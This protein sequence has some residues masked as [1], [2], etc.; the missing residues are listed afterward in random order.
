MRPGLGS[1]PT[2]TPVAL[3]KAATTVSA[4]NRKPIGENMTTKKVVLSAKKG[5]APGFPGFFGW[6]AATHPELY[7]RAQAALPDYATQYG[8]SGN[9]ANINVMAGLGAL[10]ADDVLQD[11]SAPDF[12][13]QAF[14]FGIT[15]STPLPTS[16][17]ADTI[18]NTVKTLASSILP[19]IGQ[20]KILDVQ[21]QRAKAGLPPLDTSQLS[22]AAGLNVGLTSSTQKTF[23]MVAGLGAAALIGMSLLKHR[24]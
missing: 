8:K 22:D 17:F 18:A 6:L 16:N 12:S 19:V 11:V 23:L 1:M 15:D 24:R 21:I 5:A 7:A 9:G 2:V 13:G 3:W 4:F 20:Q 10:G 14:N